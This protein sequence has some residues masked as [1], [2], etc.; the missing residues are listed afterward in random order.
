MERT[1]L[2]DIHR[3]A[4]PADAGG[5]V[6]EEVL[7]ALMER[8]HAEG[9]DLLG[10]EGLLS[11]M[12]KAV[13]E[14]ALAEELSD[15]LGY[16]RGDAAGIGSGELP[17]RGHSQA[18]AHRCREPWTW[19]CPRDRDGSFEPRIVAKGQTR[20]DGF[21]E[22]IIALYARGMTVRDVQAHLKE[23]YGV[24]VSHDLISRVTD[25][26]W[27]ELEAWRS[28]PLDAVYPVVFID[29]LMIK[30]R[31]GNV[32]N[33]PVYLAVGID[34]D[35]HK[36]ILGVWIGDS[37][38]E[39]SKYWAGVL[40]ELA[41]RG[42]AD[43]LIVVCDGLKGLPRG[44]RGHLATSNSPDLCG[45]SAASRSPLRLL[46]G[47]PPSVHG[48]QSRGCAAPDSPRAPNNRCGPTGDTTRSSPT[49]TT[50]KD[51]AAA[52][53]FHRAHAVVELAI[54]DLKEG[55]GLDHVPSGHYGANCAWLACAVLAHNIGHWTALLA[56]APP[57]TNHSRRT[58]LVAL[59]AVL[60]NRS[61]TPTLRYPARWPWATQFHTTLSALRALPGP[62]G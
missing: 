10:P 5:L 23:I 13:L 52:D 37:D 54:R 15:H 39:G 22:R 51:T 56:G 31:D 25:G 47:P 12:T 29:A 34:V 45:A 40:S 4:L 48:A 43:V 58:R 16:E 20:L 38:G 8:V 50:P 59:A 6:S 55:S 53:E 27:E 19:R 44:H 2:T 41:N 14:R 24:D 26:V 3:E 61:G 57:A 11:Q 35:G 9:T 17:Q 30:I 28:R 42:L 18:V 62:S 33:R 32:A 49:P 36:H 1:I 46:E 60:V 7:D 21:N